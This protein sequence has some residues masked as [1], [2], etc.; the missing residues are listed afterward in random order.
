MDKFGCC[1]QGYVFPRDII[2]RLLE[3]SHAEANWLVDV[4]VEYVANEEGWVRWAKAPALLQHIGAISSKGFGFEHVTKQH[5]NFG[6][7]LYKKSR[8]ATR[9]G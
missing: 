5:W 9:G 4:M 3:W 8:L 2:P 1:S 6:F 7:E